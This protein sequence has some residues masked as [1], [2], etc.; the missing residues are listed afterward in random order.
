MEGL[1]K[2]LYDKVSQLALFS[3]LLNEEQFQ[4][5]ARQKN[6]LE[7]TNI[8]DYKCI[9]MNRKDKNILQKGLFRIS[10][11]H[12][13]MKSFDIDPTLATRHFAQNQN[14]K[15]ILNSLNEFLS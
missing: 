1:E 2:D 10:R 13:W 6:L 8:F 3:T 5:I 9:I 12:C 4:I 7:S 15:R 14:N 11:G